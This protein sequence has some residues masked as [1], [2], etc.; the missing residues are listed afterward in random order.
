VLHVA[1]L[2]F[3]FTYVD[4]FGFPD[5]AFTFDSGRRK[6]SDSRCEFELA[7]FRPVSRVSEWQVGSAFSDPCVILLGILASHEGTVIDLGFKGRREDFFSLQAMNPGR[8]F[9]GYA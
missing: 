3:A 2:D 6:R 9:I 7:P 8:D 4:I 5:F 1:L